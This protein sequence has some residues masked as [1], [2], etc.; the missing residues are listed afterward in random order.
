M[1]TPNQPF[2]GVI[3]SK[4]QERMI[5]LFHPFLWFLLGYFEIS[6]LSEE[7]LSCLP[8]SLLF[9][10]WP[11]SAS[12]INSQDSHVHLS[13]HPSWSPWTS[14]FLTS[15]LQLHLFSLMTIHSILPAM[16]SKERTMWPKR[17]GLAPG[18]QAP[19]SPG[20]FSFLLSE[21]WPTNI[22]TYFLGTTL[23]VVLKKEI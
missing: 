6:L 15:R 4:A 20:Q 18:L 14:H 5:V 16:T 3:N 2:V 23:T 10:L 1:N 8:S 9:L 7:V 19:S 21:K 22:F 12:I 17:A 13:F 11:Q